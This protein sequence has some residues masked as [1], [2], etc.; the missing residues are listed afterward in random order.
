MPGL[1]AVQVLGTSRTKITQ[2]RQPEEYQ[3]R[4][5]QPKLALN[6]TLLLAPNYTLLLASSQQ[7]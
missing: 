7:S 5:S 6:H 3:Q 1:S 2:P 4:A